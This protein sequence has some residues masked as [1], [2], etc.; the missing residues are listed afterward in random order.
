MMIDTERLSKT[1][2]SDTFLRIACATYISLNQSGSGI[3]DDDTLKGLMT[4]CPERIQTD[5]CVL[6]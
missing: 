1:H 4:I 6:L 3:L 2:D 5:I